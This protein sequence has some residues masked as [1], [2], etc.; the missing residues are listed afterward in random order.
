MPVTSNPLLTPTGAWTSEYAIRTSYWLAR[1]YSLLEVYA[2]DGTLEEIHVNVASPVRIEDSRIWFL[3][4]DL[5]VSR[6]PPHEAR[7]VD[8]REFLEAVPRYGCSTEFRQ[9][10]YRAAQEAV[11]LANRWVAGGMPAIEA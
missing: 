5:D 8:E 4:Y 3:D 1:W 11:E 7:I 10:C 6:Q 9:A 2:S